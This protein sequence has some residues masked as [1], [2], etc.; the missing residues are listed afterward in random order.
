MR[1]SV[2]AVVDATDGTVALYA[3]DEEDP[4]LQT[5]MRAFPNTVQPRSAISPDLLAH[6]RYPE[7]MFKV[8]RE[9]LGRYHMTNPASWYQQSDLW[10][11]PNDPAKTATEAKEPPY[12]LSI[13]WPGDEAPIFSQTTVFVPKGRSNLASYLAVNS[14]ATSPNYGDLRVLRMSDT[15]QIDGPGQTF[16]AMTTDEKVAEVLR[17]FLNQGS[18]A[19]TFGNLLTLPMGSGLLYVLPVYTQRQ[20]S[21]GSYPALRYV[22]VRF[23]EHVGIGET[24]QEALDAV[25]V[26]DAGADTGEQPTEPGTEPDN[27]EPPAEMDASPD[28]QA[29]SAAAME[30]AEEAF[31]AADAALRRG[32]LG[33]YQEQVDEARA[34]IEQAYKALGR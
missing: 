9:I 27:G 2:K 29:V 23:G 28:D 11:V 15:Q 13:K 34:W 26:G 4:M 21:T 31:V 14:E 16:N 25:F 20:G 7:D 19:A 6:V 33:V 18:A 5:Y 8:Q 30:K 24:L 22:I 32:E 1:N 10:Q 17:P 3:W 12:Y